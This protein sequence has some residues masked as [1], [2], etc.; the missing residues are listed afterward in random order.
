[1]KPL[2]NTF[3]ILSS[4]VAIS[5]SLVG[6]G[7]SLLHHWTFDEGTGSVAADTVSA[8]DGVIIGATWTEDR[9]G[10]AGMAIQT[11]NGMWVD[12]PNTVKT[13]TGTF[14]AWIYA[15]AWG[16]YNQPAGP[17]FSAEQGSGGSNFSYRLQL[18]NTGVIAFEAIAPWG[19]GASRV[20][21]SDSTI[22]LS[23]WTHVAGTYD[24][25]TTKVYINGKLD[26]SS[27]TYDNYAGMNTSDFIRVGIGHLQGWS[28]QWFQGRIDDAMVHNNALTA[29]E[30]QQMAGTWNGYA[31]DENGWADTGDWIGWVYV[32]NQPWVWI[33]DLMSYVYFHES[34]WIWVP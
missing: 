32:A 14:S 5:C 19:N 22:P 16:G 18:N 8:A 11:G 26:G 34:G 25:Y 30:F 10:Q 15:D 6:Q 20:A 13:E 27:E 17:I 4:I 7:D 2:K 12:P 21:V 28:V 24:G 29:E 3:L 33:D 1:M 9:F 31:V 23:T